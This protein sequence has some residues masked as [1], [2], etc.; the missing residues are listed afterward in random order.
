MLY[1]QRAP[2]PTGNT[3]RSGHEEVGKRAP[4]LVPS[5][6]PGGSGDLAGRSA[7]SVKS[8]SGSQSPLWLKPLLAPLCCCNPPCPHTSASQPSLPPR[9]HHGEVLGS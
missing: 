5:A 3:M 1:G 4:G 2:D 8:V 7:W 9:Y 6:S